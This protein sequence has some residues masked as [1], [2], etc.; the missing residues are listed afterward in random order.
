MRLPSPFATFANATLSASAPVADQDDVAIPRRTGQMP[1]GA[2]EFEE[3]GTNVASLLMVFVERSM[4]QLAAVAIVSREPVLT[5][6][7]VHTLFLPS[8]TKNS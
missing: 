7:A 4:T 8:L 1:F 2:A 3:A 5:T 6:V